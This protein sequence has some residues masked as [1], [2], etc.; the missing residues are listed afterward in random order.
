MEEAEDV[1]VGGVW[2]IAQVKAAVE[3]ENW[4]VFMRKTRGGKQSFKQEER[5]TPANTQDLKGGKD[6]L[7]ERITKEINAVLFRE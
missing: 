3:Q 2:A 6:Q 4:K 1:K 5:V 7:E